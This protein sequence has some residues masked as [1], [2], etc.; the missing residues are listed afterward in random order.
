MLLY[1][2][3]YTDADQNEPN[4]YVAIDTTSFV[5]LAIE[6]APEM[7]KDGKGMSL[8]SVTL[9]RENVEQVEDFT[10]A[11]LGGRVAIIFDGE[12]VTL[13]KV[14]TI[15]EGGKLQITRCTDNACEIL[16]T[17]LAK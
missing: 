2:K 10:R 4:K 6:G 16:R 17:K 3:K 12:I 11:H 13:H 7:K 14:R 8:L 15:I 9:A 5:P 1:D